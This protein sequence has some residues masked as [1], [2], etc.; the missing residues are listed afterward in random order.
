MTLPDATVAPVAGSRATMV[1]PTG[2]L[3]APGTFE[4]MAFQAAILAGV[5]AAAA[6]F[7]KAIIV[8]ND[9]VV[10]VCWFSAV[11]PNAHSHRPVTGTSRAPRAAARRLR[12]SAR[13]S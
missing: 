4:I 8:L 7:P 9:R 10:T 5:H 12:L 1:A 11:M 3:W 13:A 6:P 2:T